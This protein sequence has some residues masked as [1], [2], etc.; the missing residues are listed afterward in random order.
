M[1]AAAKIRAFYEQGRLRMFFHA[2]NG[3]SKEFEMWLDA[4][5]NPNVRDDFGRTPLHI[6]ALMGHV[7][8]AKALLEFRDCNP[9]AIDGHGRTPLCVA[10]SSSEDDK[11][12]TKEGRA[13]IAELLRE[14]RATDATIYTKLC[15]T[16]PV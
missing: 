5:E 11:D 12:Y 2:E 6:A 8:I 10:L 13:Q 3:D 9:N 14:Q 1:D 16:G 4:V 15:P 7:E